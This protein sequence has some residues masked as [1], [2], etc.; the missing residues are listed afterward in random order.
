LSAVSKTLS[1]GNRRR[2][3]IDPTRAET[4]IEAAGERVNSRS[5]AT[6]ENSRSPPACSS[7]AVARLDPAACQLPS[8]PVVSEAKVEAF[9]VHVFC[10]DRAAF[11]LGGTDEIVERAGTLQR[12]GRRHVA[13]HAHRR[14]W[15]RETER[16]ERREHVRR[17]DP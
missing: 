11:G 16:G 2:R 10:A 13:G 12:G 6:T 8:I 9:H 14:P 17:G 1:S 5:P 15:A 4:S 7:A 3:G